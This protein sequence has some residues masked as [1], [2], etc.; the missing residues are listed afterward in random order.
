MAGFISLQVWMDL[1]IPGYMTK[2]TVLLNDG[3]P[4]EAIF[5]EGVGMIVC[6]LGSVVCSICAGG[7][8]ASVAS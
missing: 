3:S 1:E 4:P 5:V 6:S 7:V 8:A 2:I